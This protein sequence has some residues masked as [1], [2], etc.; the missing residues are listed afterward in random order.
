M[1]EI[2]GR[3]L[4]HSESI[5]QDVVISK[6]VPIGVSAY[7]ADGVL[8]DRAE[9]LMLSATGATVPMGVHI[10]KKLFG[11]KLDEIVPIGGRYE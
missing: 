6:H 9:C 11:G 4:I 2:A 8:Y 1:K 10:V 5:G 3:W 7:T